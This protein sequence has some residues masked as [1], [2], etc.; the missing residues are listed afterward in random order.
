MTEKWDGIPNSPDIDGWHWLATKKG[1]LIAAQWAMGTWVNVGS[2]ENVADRKTYLGPCV[3]PADLSAAEAAAAREMREKCAAWHDKQAAYY[4]GVAKQ[5][6]GHNRV[7][8]IAYAEQHEMHAGELR[9][10]PLPAPGALERYVAGRVAE[11]VAKEREAAEGIAQS[12]ADDCD[13]DHRMRLVAIAIRDSI[14]ARGAEARQAGE[15]GE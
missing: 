15:V 4:A 12:V 9:A 13:V 5:L 2:I 10:L 1:T 6:A 3:T 11:A 14:R 7:N 8:F